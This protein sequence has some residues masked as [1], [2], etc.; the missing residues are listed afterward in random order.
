MVRCFIA[1][2][3]IEIESVYKIQEELKPLI[4]G[5]EVE[6]ENMHVTLSFLGEIS[7]MEIASIKEKLKELSK[8]YQK[9]EATLTK[10]KLIPNERFVRVV[11]IDVAGLEDLS[12]DIKEKINGDV[13]PPHLTLARVKKVKDKKALIEFSRKFFL[14]QKIVVN[15][16]KLMK[17][18]LTRNGPIYEV[19]ETFPFSKE[20]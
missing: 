18:T 13:K 1:V 6:R 14:N 10:I 3:P 5:K 9:R 4:E 19:I 20:D 2:Y 7:E 11:A 15:D 16:I 17:S 8:Q 12:K